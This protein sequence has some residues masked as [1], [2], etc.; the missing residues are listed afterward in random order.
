MGLI[1]SA[2][3]FLAIYA[4]F[5]IQNEIRKQKKFNQNV[6]DFFRLRQEQLLS[7]KEMSF[8]ALEGPLTEAEFHEAFSC[9][10]MVLTA[11][12]SLQPEE[13]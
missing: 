7:Q 3:I 1:Q 5:D 6:K 2:L 4:A 9:H 10:L 12:L 11:E 8:N 13:E